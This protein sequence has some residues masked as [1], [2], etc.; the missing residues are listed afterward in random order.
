MRI[1]IVAATKEEIANIEVLNPKFEVDYLITGVGMTAEQQS[2]L[3]AAVP[4]NSTYGTSGEKGVGLGLLLCY[5]FVKANNGTLSVTSEV[6][7]GTT[8]TVTLPK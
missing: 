3:F 4:N 2:K 7:K 5:D 8:F 1:L 6:G